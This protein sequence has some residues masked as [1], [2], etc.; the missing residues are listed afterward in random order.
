MRISDCIF[1]GTTL[2]HGEFHNDV[3]LDFFIASEN[4]KCSSSGTKNYICKT[5]HVLRKRGVN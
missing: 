5:G 2:G 3:L 4:E 1:P